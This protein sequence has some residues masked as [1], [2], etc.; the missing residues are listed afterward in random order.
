M[1]INYIIFSIFSVLNASEDIKVYKKETEDSTHYIAKIKK[2]VIG[3]ATRE[4]YP[5]QF[6]YTGTFHEGFMFDGMTRERIFNIFENE[7]FKNPTPT[8][9]PKEK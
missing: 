2:T 1:K 7:Y 9:C 6:I 8:G 5:D 4:T 3:Y